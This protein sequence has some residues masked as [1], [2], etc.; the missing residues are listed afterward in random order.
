M[1]V[2]MPHR[3]LMN[4][5]NKYKEREKSIHYACFA[6]KAT[7][8]YFALKNNQKRSMCILILKKGYLKENILM[9]GNTKSLE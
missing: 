5:H 2:I 6:K 1:P 9:H 3:K 4:Y 7:S 8:Y